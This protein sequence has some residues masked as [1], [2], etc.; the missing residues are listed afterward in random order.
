MTCPQCN[1]VCYHCEVCMV[2]DSKHYALCSSK[3]AKW[4]LGVMLRRS[5]TE[6]LVLRSRIEVTQEG[7][8]T[9]AFAQVFKAKFKD[10]EY[11]VK[12]FSKQELKIRKLDKDLV[13]EIDLHFTL[14]HPH[15]IRL[16]YACETPTEILL[17]YELA[18]NGNLARKN[19]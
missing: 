11:A 5:P 13:S 12:E 14:D 17:L 1:E 6:R 18:S 7:L 15:I 19:A 4:S 2:S 10:K 8:G 3:K 16:G 9:G